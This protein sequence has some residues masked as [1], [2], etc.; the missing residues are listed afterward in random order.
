MIAIFDNPQD[1]MR[2][3]Q[4]GRETAK[5]HFDHVGRTRAI[6]DFMKAN[7]DPSFL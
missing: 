3:A 1:A 6:I 4:N 7:C 2:V 5:E